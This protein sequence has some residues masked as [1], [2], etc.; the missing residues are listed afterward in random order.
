M[1]ARVRLLTDEKVD[2]LVVPEQALVPQGE[3]QFVYKVVDGRA[4][5]TKVEI[6]QRREGKVEILRGLTSADRRGDGGPPEDSGRD[7]SKARPARIGPRQCAGKGCAGGKSGR[8]RQ[9]CG[10]VKQ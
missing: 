10:N 3:D 9:G 5:R 7:C 1:F 4:Q 8:R 2:S 6:G